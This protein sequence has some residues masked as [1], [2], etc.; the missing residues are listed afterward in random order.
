MYKRQ[1]FGGVL[2]TSLA[3]MLCGSGCDMVEVPGR[4]QGVS[5]FWSRWR[6]FMMRGC[7][8]P[9]LEV[10]G[11]AMD[12]SGGTQA[13]YRSDTV[14]QQYDSRNTPHMD[15]LYLLETPRVATGSEEPAED[16]LPRRG[17]NDLGLEVVGGAPVMIPLDCS[18]GTIAHLDRNT[19][20]SNVAPSYEPGAEFS[21]MAA[22]YGEYSVVL[23]EPN[24]NRVSAVMQPS[25][26][27]TAWC[28]E[29]RMGFP[30]HSSAGSFEVMHRHYQGPI[31]K[32]YGNFLDFIRARPY[33]GSN[34]RVDGF[35]QKDGIRFPEIPKPR[36][37]YNRS[38]MWA[39]GR[40]HYV[41]LD[42]RAVTAQRVGRFVRRAP[43]M[44]FTYGPAAGWTRSMSFGLGLGRVQTDG[45][46]FL[47]HEDMPAE[48]LY[49]ID[50]R[51]PTLGVPVPLEYRVF[52]CLPDDV[53]EW[54]DVLLVDT[55]FAPYRLPN[56]EQRFRQY[57]IRNLDSFDAW[58]LS[59]CEKRRE[60]RISLVDVF[61]RHDFRQHFH[62]LPTLA[63][64]HPT[65]LLYTSPSPRD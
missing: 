35:I 63:Q 53:V 4:P 61:G 36:V 27:F 23:Y 57:R 13:F 3:F 18:V 55:V 6:P 22:V 16:D 31:D 60:L 20:L 28:I 19:A 11:Y 45:V 56:T 51:E 37:N 48:F 62:A 59:Q 64:T 65:C 17:L 49:R 7:N 25:G 29:N 43:C 42:P 10:V 50:A 52:H 34:G 40:Y 32:G 39:C 54:G 30:R 8:A 9:A 26:P 5:P 41:G 15:R 33:V 38:D 46:K 1:V 14:S 12:I 44:Y 47:P 24:S 2:A 58:A 21:I